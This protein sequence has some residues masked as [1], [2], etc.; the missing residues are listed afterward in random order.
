MVSSCSRRRKTHSLAP[1]APSPSLGRAEVTVTHGLVLLLLCSLLHLGPQVLASRVLETGDRLCGM[2]PISSTSDPGI[3][4]PSL[5]GIPHKRKITQESTGGGQGGERPSPDFVPWSSPQHGGIPW[6]I[7]E[8]VRMVS[9]AELVS[10]TLAANPGCRLGAAPAPSMVDAEPP[11][12][13]A[14][15]RGRDRHLAR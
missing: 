5:R 10:R 12:R 7:A 15:P 1:R 11:G 2:A 8:A 13:C 9:P 6:A 14:F 4:K 3:K